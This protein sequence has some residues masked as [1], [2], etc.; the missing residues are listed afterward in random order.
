VLPFPA[1]C[2]YLLARSL[3]LAG[4]NHHVRVADSDLAQAAGD[5]AWSVASH[6]R[7]P[8]VLGSGFYFTKPGIYDQ[9]PHDFYPIPSALLTIPDQKVPFFM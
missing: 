2:A 6:A 3:D 1:S 7:F 8:G 5:L 4:L 9:V